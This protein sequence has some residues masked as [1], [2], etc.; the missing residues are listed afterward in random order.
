MLKVKLKHS[1]AEIA[2]VYHVLT[3]NSIYILKTNMWGDTTTCLVEDK[4]TL[5]SILYALNSGTH[6]GVSLRSARPTITTL[7]RSLTK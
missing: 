4:A 7:L 6:L 5:Q 3:K 1:T 2:E